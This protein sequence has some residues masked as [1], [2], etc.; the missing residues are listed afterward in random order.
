MGV[1]A[2]RAWKDLHDFLRRP[3]KDALARAE[4]EARLAERRL[5]DAVDALPEGIVFLDPEVVLARAWVAAAQGAVSE[6]ITL[7]HE[8]AAVAVG[9]GQLAHEM[10]ALHTAVCFGDRTAADRLTELAGQVDGP[11]A[12]AAAA[13][14]TALAA[15]DGEALTAASAQLES[16]GA[17]LLAADAAAQA[18]QAHS[19]QGRR[20]LANLAVAHAYRL[21]EACEGART[22]ALAALDAPAR[23]TERERE[24]ASL[25]AA[26]LRNREIAE[27]L[28]VS[29]RTV[30]G[31]LYRISAKLGTSNRAALAGLLGPAAT[32][33]RRERH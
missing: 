32:R 14:A 19:R 3:D 17:L 16:S 27:R 26:G 31:H 1:A 8:A 20:G 25:A 7:A 21:A 11:R 28:T 13:H 12:P 6:A 30:E 4:N 9:R 5:R 22:P 10:L 33:T 2:A 15:G 23:L 24:I 29:V 18:A